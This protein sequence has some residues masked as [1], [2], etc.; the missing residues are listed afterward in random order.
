MV[1]GILQKSIVIIVAVLFVASASIIFY[2]F[3]N[4]NRTQ[5]IRIF[6]AAEYFNVWIILISL[7]A[8]IA[9]G[10]FNHFE[11]KKSVRAVISLNYAEASQAL[12]SNGTR[13]NMTEI[14]SEEVIERAIKKGAFKDVTVK[15]L[16]DC[17]EV[18]PC[19]EGDVSDES[20]HHISTEF[21]VEYRASRY[22][23]HLDSGNVVKL[24]AAA[25]K[26]YYI[27]KYADNFSPDSEKPDFADMEY[28]DI[29]SYL[30]KETQS[31]LNYLYGL[32][33]K[34][35]SFV[36]GNGSTFNSIASKVYQFRETQIEQNLKS[37][38]LQ[39]GIARDKGEYLGRLS[40]HNKNIDFERQ[41]NEASYMLCNQ[42][43][44]MYKEEMIRIVLV[45]TWDQVGKYYMGR[46]KVGVDE[47]SVMATSF[48]DSVASKE[49][50]IMDNKLVMDKLS[51]S[52]PEPKLYE[53]A[54]ILIASIYDNIKGFEKEAIAAG[55]EYSQY[56][57]N[58]CTAVSIYEVSFMKEFRMLVLFAAFSYISLLLYQI[59]KK[60]P[61][62]A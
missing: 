47:L 59:S 8:T 7:L 4:V 17:L 10:I 28:M 37:F 39:N 13:Y 32:A 27:E 6:K 38:V 45:P 29:V 21:E 3:K 50:E 24:I 43:V 42:A 14:I 56:R 18:S 62:K 46:T 55:R 58:Q 19:V 30:N 40:Y 23:R 53:A 36:T 26:E 12:N 15:Q 34:N 57:M 16:K 41:K 60:F 48:S 5:R 61:Q 2:R 35:S 20:K 11:L 44:D 25:Y 33:I 54:D 9:F 49:K 31:I 22:T 51:S 52:N 1:V